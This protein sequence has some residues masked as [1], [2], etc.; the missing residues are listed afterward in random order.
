MSLLALLRPDY[1]LQLCRRKAVAIVRT[2]GAIS[3]DLKQTGAR[4]S[5]PGTRTAGH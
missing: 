2:V 4:T 1:S 3:A 5:I